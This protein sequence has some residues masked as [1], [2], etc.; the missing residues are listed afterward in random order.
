MKKKNYIKEIG[1]E[2]EYNQWK[3]DLKER[4]FELSVGDKVKIIGKAESHSQGW[5]TTWVDDMDKT[6][7]LVGY[8]KS[9]DKAA[10]YNVHTG[11]SSWWYPRHVLKRVDK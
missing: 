6:I 1:L 3:K 11:S 8:I 4:S 5:I 2:K 9:I 10:G 7:G